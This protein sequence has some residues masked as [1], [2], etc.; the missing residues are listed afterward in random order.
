MPIACSTPSSYPLLTKRPNPTFAFQTPKGLHRF[1]SPGTESKAGRHGWS[2]GCWICPRL[3]YSHWEC[4]QTRSVFA[5]GCRRSWAACHQP[6]EQE[7]QRLS[8]FSKFRT[9]DTTISWVSK[10]ICIVMFWFNRLICIYIMV[11]AWICIPL[12]LPE[13]KFFTESRTRR[14]IGL[15]AT[16]KMNQILPLLQKMYQH[17]WTVLRLLWPDFVH[18]MY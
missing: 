13:C 11:F 12:C 4:S 6:S 18:Y 15:F 3:L 10:K 16:K 9:Q 2:V 17:F 8:Y 5:Q 7:E 14:F 1:Q